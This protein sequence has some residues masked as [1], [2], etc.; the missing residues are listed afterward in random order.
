MKGT[1][2]TL[3]SSSKTEQ[4]RL[5]LVNS[6][7]ICSSRETSVAHGDPPPNN[8]NRQTKIAKQLQALPT[9]GHVIDTD[10][11]TLWANRG[12]YQEK[13]N[14]HNGRFGKRPEIR[15]RKVRISADPLHHRNGKK[16]HSTTIHRNNPHSLEEPNNDT[17]DAPPGKWSSGRYHNATP[18]EVLP[19]GTHMRRLTHNRNRMR[20]E[21]TV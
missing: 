14:L 15:A 20:E 7:R 3:W 2:I 12:S 16:H 19:T 1:T 5:D 21:D 6:E 9:V 8:Y 18:D 13:Q 4:R 11:I 10:D 17:R